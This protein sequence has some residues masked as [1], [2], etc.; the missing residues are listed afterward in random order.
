MG[1]IEGTVEDGDDSFAA[2]CVSK[3]ATGGDEAGKTVAVVVRVGRAERID[4]HEHGRMDNASVPVIDCYVSGPS[5][6][7]IA[8]EYEV[9]GPQG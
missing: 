4:T 3:D 8:E 1:K 7:A 9:S 5:G 6:L 2:V